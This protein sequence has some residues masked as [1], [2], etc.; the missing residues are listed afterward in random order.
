MVAQTITRT[1]AVGSRMPIRD[2]LENVAVEL[3]MVIALIDEFEEVIAKLID[4]GGSMNRIDLVGLQKID[5]LKQHAGS[6][7]RYVSVIA[8][9]TN[10]AWIVDTVE[11]LRMVSLSCVARR[12]GGEG[13]IGSPKQH[14][15]EDIELFGVHT[16]QD[17]NGRNSHGI[18]RP[19]RYECSLVS[20]IS[21]VSGDIRGKIVNISNGGLG[22]VLQS[23]VRLSPGDR[24]LVSCEN[25]RSIAC[26]IR[27]TA[28][29][30]YGAVCDDDLPNRQRL[31][32]CI[33]VV[34]STSRK[35]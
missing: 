21:T 13:Q 15:S 17:E 12:L 26:V 16:G 9:A 32:R 27:W 14:N 2:S 22:F 19:T 10:P 20:S 28:H 29:P 25:V 31:K 7:E 1:A 34:V 18:D 4:G 23:A 3:A 30:R 5:L 6:I 8:S 11:A 24:V 33:E 35:V